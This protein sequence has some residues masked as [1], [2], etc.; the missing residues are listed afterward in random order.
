LTRRQLLI[1]VLEVVNPWLDIHM[2]KII[3]R[4]MRDPEDRSF[5]RIE[6]KIIAFEI[7]RHFVIAELV[8]TQVDIRSIISGMGR[9]KSLQAVSFFSFFVIDEFI[10]STIAFGLE[11][12][13]FIQRL[14]ISFNGDARP[15]FK[16]VV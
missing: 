8:I 13:S 7:L 6:F 15:S 16:S 14:I 1:N 11:E 4:M 9:E 10:V 5:L 12:G 3:V 2:G